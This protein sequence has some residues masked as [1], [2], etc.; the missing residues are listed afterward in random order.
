MR[1]LLSY[2]IQL[3]SVSSQIETTSLDTRSYCHLNYEFNQNGSFP[4]LFVGK[5][6]MFQLYQIGNQNHA[7]TP[8]T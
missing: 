5:Y 8:K 7:K 1:N 2:A 3:I 4:Q 6:I